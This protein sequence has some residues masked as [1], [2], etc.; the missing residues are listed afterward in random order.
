M[1]NEIEDDIDDLFERIEALEDF[2]MAVADTVG[3]GNP[4]FTAALLRRLRNGIEAASHKEEVE[5]V[6]ALRK[7]VRALERPPT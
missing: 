6:D 5:R 3:T 2:V 1:D 7:Y 4:E